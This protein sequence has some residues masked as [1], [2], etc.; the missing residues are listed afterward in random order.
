VAYRVFQHVPHMVELGF[1]IAVRIVDPVVDD[2][3][4][5]CLGIDVHAGDDADALDDAMRIAAVLAPH[6]FDPMREIL[7]RHRVVEHEITVVRQLDIL[8]RV[9]PYQTPAQAFAFQVT[10]QRIMAHVLCVSCK[11]RQRVI[12]LT[13]QQIL[14][15]IQAGRFHAS[16]F[17]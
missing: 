14:A 12:R 6:Q 17:T 13:H 9:L 10:V 16:H 1:A 8:T 7:V 3:V 2:P 5:P 15:V 11:I 4:A